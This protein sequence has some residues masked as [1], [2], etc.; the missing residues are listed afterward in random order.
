M[1]WQRAAGLAII[2][3]GF[4]IVEAWRAA[5]NE[6][7]QRA[8]GGIEPQGDV[9]AWMS[10]AY[11]ASFALMLAEGM[12][13]GDAPLP[14]FFAGAFVF[15]L[16]KALKWWAIVTLG[17]FWTFRVIVVPGTRRIE[18]GPYRL[19]AHPNYAGVAGE[20]AG[21]AL[22]TSAAISGPVATGLFL[23]LMWRRVGVER[24]ALDAILRL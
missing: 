21:S 8:R 20:L 2:V 4:M 24:R 7:I 23:W 5:R 13:R 19:M 1:A 9:Y 3:F 6:R 12:V 11:P 16:G 15:A 18:R 14:L 17:S 10:V 22:M